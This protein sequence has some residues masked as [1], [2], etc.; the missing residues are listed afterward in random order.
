MFSRL[1]VLSVLLSLTSVMSAEGAN[2]QVTVGGPGGVTT[3]TPNS[4]VGCI[5]QPTIRNLT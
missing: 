1:F 3:Y 4:V 2:I 5:L